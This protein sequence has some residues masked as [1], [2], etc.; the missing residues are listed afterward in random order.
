MTAPAHGPGAGRGLGLAAAVCVGWLAAAPAAPAQQADPPGRLTLDRAVELALDYHPSVRAARAAERG[1]AARAG[2]ASSEWWPSLQADGSLFQYQ[3]DMLVFPIHEL[4]PDAFVFDRTLIQGGLQLGWTLF[5]GFGRSSRAKGARAQQQAAESRVESSEAAL[6][7][8]VS[9][10]YLEVLSAHGI[11]EAQQQ[12][13]AALA[14]ERERVG[15]LLEQGQAAEVERL[16]VEAAYAEAEAERIAAER[17]LDTAE[18]AL[19]RMLGLRAGTVR[20]DRLVP[21]R[22]AGIATEDR[23][24]LIDRFE[25]AN[26]DLAAARSL[27]DAAERAHGAATATWWPRFDVAGSYQ[28][29]TSPAFE[30]Q[31]LWQIGVR[32]S[33]PLFTGGARSNA[34]SAAG[35]QAA[36]AVE[37]LELAR[38]HGHDAVDRALSRVQE[39]SARVDALARAAEHLAE[40]A[41]IEQLALDAGRGIQTDYLRAEASLR[42]ARAAVVQARHAEIA[43]RVE[44]ARVVGDLSPHWLAAMLETVS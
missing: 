25:A 1:A 20:A 41:R 7:A 31:D 43:A 14:A 35:A 15:H 16:R 42:R 29:F 32:L 44:L 9:I 11:L 37:Q 40:V 17:A 36:E 19:A 22:L 3:K 33:Y 34:V 39:Q 6:L 12:S 26:P 18:R 21:V 24:A 30:V 2:G 5:D 27:R 13:L 28:L 10:T 8:D 38:L 23:T 4:S